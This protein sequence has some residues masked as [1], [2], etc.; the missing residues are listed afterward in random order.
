MSGRR[1]T[2][3]TLAARAEELQALI[4]RDSAFTREL[5]FKVTTVTPGVCTLA[6]PWKP[7]FDRPGGIVSGQ[8]LMAAADVAMW[9]AIKTL[10]GMGD[11]SVTSHM[12]TQ[13]LRSL[14]GEGF[15]CTATILRLGRRSAFGTAECVSPRGELLTHHTIAYAAPAP[16]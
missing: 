10:R 7:E 11:T 13:F 1:S 5:G 16:S 4:S 14:R 9:L 8:V 6:V 12:Q 2:A 3:P 15:G